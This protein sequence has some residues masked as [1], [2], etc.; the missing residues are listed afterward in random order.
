MRILA[1][2]IVGW[3][4]RGLAHDLDTALRFICEDE[5]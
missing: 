2:L 1:A 3:W 5:R 4:L